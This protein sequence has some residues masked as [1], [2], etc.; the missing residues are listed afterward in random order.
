M[1]LPDLAP[2]VAALSPLV[3]VTYVGWGHLAHPNPDVEARC[4]RIG[5]DVFRL[6]TADAPALNRLAAISVPFSFPA[7]GEVSSPVRRAEHWTGGAWDGYVTFHAGQAADVTAWVWA[8]RQLTAVQLDQVL[9]GL[10]GVHFRD[11]IAVFVDRVK[12][13]AWGVPA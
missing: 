7:P 13:F 6:H 2:V 11:D 4:D 3:P 5:P 9:V 12:G 10:S 8:L 1:T